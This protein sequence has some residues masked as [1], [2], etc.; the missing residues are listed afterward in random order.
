MDEIIRKELDLMF[1][2]MIDLD[3]ELTATQLVVAQCLQQNDEQKEAF[4]KDI[5]FTKDIVYKDWIK[6][7][8]AREPDNAL[9]IF[10]DEFE[11]N[12]L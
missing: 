11:N 5:K 9:R 4:E 12:N 10:G 6:K 8:Y 1:K 3:S 7:I 2:M